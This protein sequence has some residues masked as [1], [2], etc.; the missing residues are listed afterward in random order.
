MNGKLTGHTYNQYSLVMPGVV[1]I[2]DDM[3]KKIRLNKESVL[4]AIENVKKTRDL[5][6]TYKAFQAN[7]KKYE[8]ALAFL[9]A[10][11]D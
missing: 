4:I 7:L 9:E 11:E 8:G 6:A 3:R 1:E 10:Q 2:I 5:Y